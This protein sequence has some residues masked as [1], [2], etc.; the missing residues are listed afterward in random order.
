MRTIFVD[1]QFVVAIANEPDQQHE[2]AKD[3]AKS[4][5][6][7]RFVVTE[8]V[9][10]EIGNALARKFKDYAIHAIDQFLESKDTELVRLTPEMFEA[11]YSLYK[12][13]RDKEWG[14]VDCISF[15]VMR[16]AGIDDAL[17]F[18]QHFVQAGFRALMRD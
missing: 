8:P 10:L 4:C 11:G 2:R 15:I 1:T 18:D 7:S 16:K 3:L 12:N 9:L 14:L 17:T 5:V 6:G 13:H